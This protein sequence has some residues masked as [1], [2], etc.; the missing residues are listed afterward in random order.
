MMVLMRQSNPHK[1]N[2]E[3]FAREKKRKIPC[4]ALSFQAPSAQQSFR[5]I[6]SRRCEA[7]IELLLFMCMVKMMLNDFSDR[8]INFDLMHL[9]MNF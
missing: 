3:N 9:V 7:D 8:A 2:D 1:S 4:H 6:E 5:E